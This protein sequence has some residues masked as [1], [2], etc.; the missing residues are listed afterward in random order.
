MNF[1]RRPSR[2]MEER[3]V[4]ARHVKAKA[5]IVAR[6]SRSVAPRRS[7]GDVRESVAL[8]H[9]PAAFLALPIALLAALLA[10]A[11]LA[12]APASAAETHVFTGSFG[13]EGSGAGQLNER[14]K[15]VRLRLAGAER[16]RLRLLAHLR[17]TGLAVD[18]ATGDV[19]VADTGNDRV[20]KFDSAGTFIR[21]FI[22]GLPT[23]A[24]A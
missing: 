3:F 11:A 5:R 7:S 20:D 16:I 12:A 21:A 9:R 18:Q 4:K 24:P 10:I 8:S 22:G 14:L 15:N 23:G 17:L 1:D 2:N 19:Y 6:F 13:S